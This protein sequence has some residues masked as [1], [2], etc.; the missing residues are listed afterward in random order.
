MLCWEMLVL[1]L[2]GSVGVLWAANTTNEAP[3]RADKERLFYLS[4]IFQK[5][6][7]DDNEIP[8]DNVQ[9]LLANL[10]LP[11]PAGEGL[12]LN[13]EGGIAENDSHCHDLEA[14]CPT[15]PTPLDP[16]DRH[17]HK[18]SVATSDA[19]YNHQKV[20]SFVICLHFLIFSPFNRLQFF[21]NLN[22]SVWII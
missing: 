17:I 19:H 3:T 15:T 18:R 22:L 5:Y 4:T 7:T 6:S 2:W 16:S 11:L 13:S 14:G 1:F 21:L 10:G 12:L 20:S 8:L 9:K